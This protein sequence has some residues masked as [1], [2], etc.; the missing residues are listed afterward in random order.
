[1]YERD[2]EP[3]GQHAVAGHV[4]GHRLRR[5]L[6][7]DPLILGGHCAGEVVGQPDPAPRTRRG[8]LE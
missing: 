6:G 7:V 2:L 8:K 5:G 1:M 3:V 4:R